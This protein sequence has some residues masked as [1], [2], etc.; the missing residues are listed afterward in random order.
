MIG[1]GAGR[2]TVHR[3]MGCEEPES[4]LLGRRAIVRCKFGSDDLM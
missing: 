3:M 1:A 2:G 4:R